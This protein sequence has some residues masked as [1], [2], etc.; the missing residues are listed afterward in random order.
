MSCV[1]W[2]DAFMSTYKCWERGV[3]NK[4]PQN[5]GKFGPPNHHTHTT[6]QY[7]HLLL[8]N[9]PPSSSAEGI[10]ALPLICQVATPQNDIPNEQSAVKASV[11][12]MTLQG[13]DATVHPH[14]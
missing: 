12:E 14:Q 5:F 8:D 4:R 6:Y 9:I 7:N 10:Q 2:E 11:A 3:P 13:W 1:Q